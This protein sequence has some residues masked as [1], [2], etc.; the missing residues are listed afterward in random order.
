MSGIQIALPRQHERPIGSFEFAPAWVF[1]TPIVLQWILLGLR[2]GDLSLPT[3]ANPNIEVGGLC[4]ESKSAILDQVAPSQRD[5]V[6]PYTRVTSCDVAVAEAARIAAGLTYPI[7]AKPDI[8][9]N[10]TGVRLVRD[11][12]GLA[13]YLAAFPTG[14]AIVLQAFVP[15]EGEA[16]L[17]F[18]RRP[19]DA[20]GQLTSL[21]LKEPPSVIGDGRK[22]LRELILRD[23]RLSE[24]Q[25]F[26]IPRLGARLDGV[27]RNAERVPLV[28]VGNHCKGS[29]FHD[30]RGEIT[31]ALTARIDA[32]ARALPEF[33]FGRFDVRYRSLSSLRRGEDFQIIEIKGVG[34]EAT[35]VWDPQTHLLPAWRDQFFHY[36]A[37]FQIGR[38]NRA[39][40]FKSAGVMA[41]LRHWRLQRRLMAAYPAHD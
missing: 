27:P 31:P 16:G 5:V 33:H 23:A 34:S 19:G 26:F 37:A 29:T 22:N 35:H 38:V 28:F 18:I 41:M 25:H 30:G 11:R 12:A 24:I 39:R 32:I 40:G 10:G 8:G 36:R 13:A 14:A 7:V 4:G 9:C 3:V 1:Y 21:T 6:A 15:Y 17:F 2:Y 20:S